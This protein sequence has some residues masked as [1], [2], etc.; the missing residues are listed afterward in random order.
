MAVSQKLRYPQWRM[1]WFGWVPCEPW[2]AS[3]SSAYGALDARN[4][5]VEAGFHPSEDANFP[6]LASDGALDLS[7]DTRTGLLAG[8]H[9][10]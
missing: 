6:G 7:F 1:D 10:G 2:D 8:K 9:G 3:G 4:L 5:T